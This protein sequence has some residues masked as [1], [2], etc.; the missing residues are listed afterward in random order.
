[1]SKT[2]GAQT[3]SLPPIILGGSG[4]TDNDFEFLDS[5]YAAG[6]RAIDVAR[7]YGNGSKERTLGTW[8]ARRGHDDMIII[9][10]GCHGDQHGHRVS[11]QALNDDLAAST[12]ALQGATISC[13]L[14]HRDEPSIPC[15]EIISWLQPHLTNGNI[16]SIGVSNWQHQRIAAAN[17][18]AAQHNAIPF[19]HTSPQYSAI[20]PSEMPWPGCLS[21]SGDDEAIAW[22]RQ[23]TDLHIL[24]WQPLANGYLT[25]RPS[26]ALRSGR[27]D[28]SI[29]DTEKNRAIKNAL[30]AEAQK[31]GRSLPQQALAW[32]IQQERTHAILGT[33]SVERWQEAMAI[34][35]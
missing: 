10:K 6:G 12:E 31:R 24:A 3:I 14:L 32:L 11:E 8:L 9:T 15:D 23:Q 4:I 25:E 33:S 13:Y 28:Y 27:G 2:Q 35:H 17:A 21:L 29:F 1:M 20:T 22:H 26:S 34:L 30:R 5:W 16:A 7:A 18:W 19:T